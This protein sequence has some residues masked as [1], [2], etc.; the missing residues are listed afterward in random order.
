MA[1]KAKWTREG[2]K[3][4]S[5]S[6]K[7][8]SFAVQFY[9]ENCVDG[10]EAVVRAI[11][12][13]DPDELRIIA[14]CHDN[15]RTAA[16]GE[17][18][19]PSCVK[20]HFHVVVRGGDHSIKP[21]VGATL[22]KLGIKFREGEDDWMLDA[23]GIESTGKLPDYISFLLHRPGY[24]GDGDTPYAVSALISNQPKEELEVLCGLVAGGSDRKPDSE[25]MDHLRDEARKLGRGFGNFIEWCDELPFDFGQKTK[26]AKDLWKHYD[27]GVNDRCKED[28]N[29]VRLSVF[30]SGPPNTGKST[31]AVTALD[32]PNDRILRIAGA[33][34]GRFDNLRPWTKAIVVDDDTIPNLLNMAD[35]RITSPYSRVKNNL[36][37]G[38]YLIVTYN[39]GFDAWLAKCAIKDD[40]IAAARD[41]FYICSIKG[42][43][44]DRHL[45][46]ES[47]CSRGN[48]QTQRRRLEM[49]RIF[50]KNF[51]L[52]L[53]SYDPSERIDYEPYR[54]PEFR[55]N[56]TSSSTN[57]VLSFVQMWEFST[58][59]WKDA[60]MEDESYERKLEYLRQL[61]DDEIRDRMDEAGFLR[62]A[63]FFVKS[64]HGTRTPLRDQMEEYLRRVALEAASDAA[65]EPEDYDYGN[66]DYSWL[67]VEASDDRDAAAGPT[68]ECQKDGSE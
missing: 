56:D 15:D 39:A 68:E 30:I 42:T 13:T 8:A 38:E 22:R 52:A 36:W 48:E 10:W 31:S 25:M 35:N 14:I 63:I 59:F 20:R 21:R 43:G 26:M 58:W 29:V 34:R 55:K 32:V 16:E 49:F 67:S 44:K 60:G 50:Q 61:T 40:Q 17:P 28:E 2:L 11:K 47:E 54:A 66:D 3:V 51:D 45:E 5:L 9:D 6:G 18:W 1:K 19:Q 4:P 46:L 33:G 53:R 65:V 64:A 37:A 62:A 41:R 27:L 12:D 57:L 7:P 23:H 24:P